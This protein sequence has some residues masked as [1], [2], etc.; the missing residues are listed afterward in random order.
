MFFC[1]LTAS[2]VTVISSHWFYLLTLF[3]RSRR[4]LAKL[5]YRRCCDQVVT[6]IV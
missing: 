5:S 2:H 1:C 6:S 3:L 4:S